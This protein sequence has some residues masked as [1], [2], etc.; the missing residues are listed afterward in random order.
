MSPVLNV[1][2]VSPFG[3]GKMLLTIARIPTLTGSGRSGQA[4]IIRCRLGSESVVSGG[5]SCS[6]GTDFGTLGGGVL[7]R[8][9]V[10][11]PRFPAVR[12]QSRHHFRHHKLRRMFRYVAGEVIAHLPKGQLAK[13]AEFERRDQFYK[14]THEQIDENS[15]GS[16]LAVGDDPTPC[17]MGLAAGLWCYIFPLVDPDK[18][19]Y[20]TDVLL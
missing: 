7:S 14:A 4:L 8:L 16:L 5:F 10:R 11:D 9:D 6:R 17:P 1:H 18:P 20:I 2:D 3:L 12:H 19:R 13:L 15:I